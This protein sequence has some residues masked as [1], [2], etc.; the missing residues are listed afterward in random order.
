RSTRGRE[1]RVGKMAHMMRRAG[2]AA[3]VLLP[4]ILAA[5]VHRGETVQLPDPVTLAKAW[6]A[7]HRPMPPAPLVRHDHVVRA[8]EEARR[9]WGGDLAVEVIGHSV[10]GRALHH[11]RLGT[12]PTGVLLWSQMHGDEP[13]ATVAL[14]DLLK[15]L[16][17]HRDEPVVR[18]LLE[19]LTLHIIPML[20]P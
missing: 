18:R 2:L 8:I 6:D 9:D 20:H 10:E 3:F 15:Y 12:G 7:E 4:V 5:G 13:T 14:F 17:R 16:H 19:R 1:P 11:L